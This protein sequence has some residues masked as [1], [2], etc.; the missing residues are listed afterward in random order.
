[1]KARRAKDLL[2]LSDG[3]FFETVSEG[4]SLVLENA[5]RLQEAS[6]S[7]VDAEHAQGSQIL[8]MLAQ[9]EAAKF[10]ILM[11]AVRCPRT[12]P[13][14]GRQLGYFHDHLARG[15]Y[16][17]LASARPVDL[18]ELECYA[19]LLR[20]TLYLDGPNDVDWIFRN[21]LQAEREEV[22]YVDYVETSDGHEWL[23]PRNDDIMLYFTGE[24]QALRISRA[25]HKTGMTSPKGLAVVAKIWRQV[26]VSLDLQWDEVA[27]RNKDV[28]RE[29]EQDGLLNPESGD[30]FQ[31]VVFDWPL[32]LYT[33]DLR[34]KDVARKELEERQANWWPDC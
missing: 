21:R 13:E 20:A 32:P 11:D 25:L 33:L 5:T 27:A 2:Q 12:F 16:A 7:L 18:A 29:L 9:E 17:T 24:P 15:I 1:M 23:S 3:D 6:Q 19:D 10:L 30:V 28:L 4:L 14:R 34:A 26:E 31:A 22:M 8:N